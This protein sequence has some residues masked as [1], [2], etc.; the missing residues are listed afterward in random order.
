LYC[1]GNQENKRKAQRRHPEVARS[2]SKR[3][4]RLLLIMKYM[5]RGDVMKHAVI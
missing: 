4:R 5:L 2:F 3:L 1:K